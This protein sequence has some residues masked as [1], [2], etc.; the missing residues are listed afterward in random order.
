MEREN[1]QLNTLHLLNALIATLNFRP[2]VECPPELRGRLGVRP[3][4]ISIMEQKGIQ[5]IKT[6]ERYASVLQCRPEELMEF[7]SSRTRASEQ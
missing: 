4:N 7:T 5:Q 2:R 6:A 1:F 3:N